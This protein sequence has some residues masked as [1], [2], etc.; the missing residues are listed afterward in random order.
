MG[1]FG[2]IR[3][4]FDIKLFLHL[5]EFIGECDGVLETTLCS[6]FNWSHKVGV[7]QLHGDPGLVWTLLRVRLLLVLAACADIAGDTAAKPNTVHLF[8]AM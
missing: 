5:G 1:L 2:C 4:C 7:H 6:R 3:F 8:L